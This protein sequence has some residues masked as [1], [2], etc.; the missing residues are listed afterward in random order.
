[1][2]QETRDP[3]PDR[4]EG[5]GTSEAEVHRGCV[6]NP[7]CTQLNTLKLLLQLLLKLLKLLKVL[8]AAALLLPLQMLV[9]PLQ[10]ILVLPAVT[11]LGENA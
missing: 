3:P 8:L 2:L 10:L 4:L 5:R 7:S 9:L 6:H 11:R 1:M